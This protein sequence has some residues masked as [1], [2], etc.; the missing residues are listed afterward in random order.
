MGNTQIGETLAGAVFNLYDSNGNAVSGF[1]NPYTT[2]SSGQI[3]ISNLPYGDYYLEEQTAPAGYSNLD[4]NN[5]VSGTAQK[6]RVYFSI[7]DNT[8]T[9]YLTCSDEMSPAYIRLFEHINEKLDAWGDPTFIFKITN[10]GTGKT[11]L[12]SLTVND[13]GTITDTTKHRVLKWIDDTTEKFFTADPINNSYNSW[14][15]EATSETEYKG[16]YHID[17]QGRIRVEPGNYEISRMPVSRYKFVTSGHIVYDTN[18]TTDPYLG[19]FTT[20]ATQKVTINDLEAGKTADVHYYDEVEYYDKFSHVDTKINKFYK[21]ENGANTTIKGIRISDY[22]ITASGTLN[23]TGSDLT[24]YAIYAD[25]T[26]SQITDAA[27]LGKITFSYT[28]VTGEPAPFNPTLSGDNK[29][30][31]VTDVA[32]YNNKVYTITATYDS[33]FTTTFDLVF[34]RS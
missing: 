11:N 28:D 29:T 23:L 27:E 19:S 7:G 30:L 10:K 26:E 15:V 9:K 32:T 20:D 16:M 8:T 1:T 31:T 2:D 21:L 22:H 13:D 25:G 17:S 34:A 33:K 14:L 24:V 5:V 18:T 4:S 6:K 3:T 12:V